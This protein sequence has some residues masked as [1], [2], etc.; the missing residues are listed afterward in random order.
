MPEITISEYRQTFA[1]KPPSE[2]TVRRWI[3]QGKLYGVK[4]GHWYVDPDRQV[5]VDSTVTEDGMAQKR[6]AKYR[7]LP[8]N[9]HPQVKKGVTYYR[10]R[11]P[12]HIK[13]EKREIPL[14]S[15]KAQAIDAARQ[16]NQE[17]GV[18]ASLV[19][20]AMAAIDGINK[21]FS[22]FLT[23]FERD[24]LPRR[25]VKGEPLSPRT[26]QAYK[27]VIAQYREK[28]G[29]L[30]FDE[31]QQAHIADH[32]NSLTPESAT[33][34]RSKL[35]VIWK[36]AISDGLT[37]ENLPARIVPPDLD[38]TKRRRLSVDEY[39]AIYAQAPRHI[40][41]AMELALNALQRRADLQKLRFSDVR[42]GYLHIVVS[43][44]RKHGKESYVRIP[45]AL[46]L[47]HSES[48]CKTLGDLVALCRDDLA[49]PFLIHWEPARKTKS[50]EK[51]HWTQLSPKQLSDGFAAAR[52]AAGV[53]ADVPKGERP[54]LHEC[55]A[56]GQRLYVAAGYSVEWVQTMRG[57]SNIDTTKLYLEGHT[58]WTTVHL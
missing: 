31:I 40:Q 51:A 56:L 42:D 43:K 8:Q 27:Q 39:K 47:I 21:D 4:R 24:I 33:T 32:L 17:Y 58:E 23:R 22:A 13:A 11:V 3:K 52:D 49:S 57:H 36:Y 10:Y 9:L 45:T 2:K 15:N 7:D 34:H 12:S 44:T 53:Q 46:P 48:G 14:G 38:K 25:K 50:K 29:H 19:S 30:T 6:L 54:G 1:G 18:G 41:M 35:I 16:L 28:W 55:I 26:L 20:R 37:S 5:S